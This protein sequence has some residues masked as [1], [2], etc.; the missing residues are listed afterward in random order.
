[1]RRRISTLTISRQWIELL[2]AATPELPDARRQRFV[3]QYGLSDYDAGVLTEARPRADYFEAT[4]AAGA[5]NTKE[6][7][8]AVANWVNGDLAR[9]LNAANLEIEDC[10]ITPAALSEV[11][12]LVKSGTISGKT[13]K[14]VFEEMF[15]TGRSA[16]E[17]VQDSGVTQITSGDEISYAVKRVIEQHLKPVEDYHHGK[18][19]AIKF[20]VGQV[21]RETQG[22]ARPDLVLKIL[23]EKLDARP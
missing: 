10:K 14:S 8:K 12:D 13:A 2:R 18:D 20:L 16:R 4:L 5:A 15:R 9:L 1:M 6:L 22:R 17:I 3:Q 23:R 21:M 11:L 7:A 19:E